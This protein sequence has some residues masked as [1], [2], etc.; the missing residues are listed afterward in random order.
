VELGDVRRERRAFSSS[1]EI[2]GRVHCFDEV[3]KEEEGGLLLP[4]FLLFQDPAGL[5]FFAS[6]D[7]LE[8]DWDGAFEDGGVGAGGGASDGGEEAGAGA[9]FE[10]VGVG[11]DFGDGF[12][13]EVEE[14]GLPVRF[15]EDAFVV[16]FLSGGGN[17]GGF[18]VFLLLCLFLA[19]ASFCSCSCY[20]WYFILNLLTTPAAA[21]LPPSR[22]R[23]PPYNIF[24][25]RTRKMRSQHSTALQRLCHYCCFRA[26][27]HLLKQRPCQGGE[28]EAHGPYTYRSCSCL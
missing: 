17:G 5:G 2:K 14:E 9:A 24:I 3:D 25:I 23:P 16:G 8:G 22:L 12:G 21:A 15:G 6:H 13:D 19:A 20:C 11:F 7:E 10:G 26:R 28:V 1:A 18:A 4:A 27:H